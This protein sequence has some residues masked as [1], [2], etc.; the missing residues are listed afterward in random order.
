MGEQINRKLL[1][2]NEGH[3]VFILEIQECMFPAFAT[4]FET[5]SLHD[6]FYITHSME[7]LQ[8]L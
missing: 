8:G 4:K 5:A 6:L 3:Y 7:E 2:Y 1:Y